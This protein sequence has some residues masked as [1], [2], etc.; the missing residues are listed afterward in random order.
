MPKPFKP[1]RPFPLPAGAEVV[2]HDGRQCY[3]TKDK[4]R[5]V[6]Y[7]LTKD[8]RQY[9]RP[10]RNYYFDIKDEN[11]T[12]RRIKGSTDKAITEQMIADWQRRIERRKLGYTDLA[13]E[14]ARRP[15]V[16]HL[17]DYAAHLEAK[18][19]T[20]GHVAQTVSRIRAVFD[21][22]GFV[23]PRN[24]DAGKVATWLTA[25]RRG[26]A[27]V[28]IPPGEA[29]SSSAVAELVGLT[30]DAVRRFVGSSPGTGSR[31]WATGRPDDSPAPPSSGSLRR[32]R[33]GH[34]PGPST[35]TRSRCVGSP[36]G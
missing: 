33:R 24:L 3:R 9:L 20:P 25:L 15:L 22:C 8:G 23:I 2:E 17:K 27:A 30:V 1:T 4:G 12:V 11:G 14:H 32:R 19:D 28:T 36:A 31:P 13:E 21:G 35:G 18:G 26:G 10:A 29:F 5:T 16:E 6:F 34:R 7:P